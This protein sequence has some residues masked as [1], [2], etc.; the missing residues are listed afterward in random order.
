MD[1]ILF[2]NDRC[3]FVLSAVDMLG[4]GYPSIL[5][6]SFWDMIMS[7]CYMYHAGT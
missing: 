3:H 5:H 7:P 6:V 4:H 1:V 2:Y